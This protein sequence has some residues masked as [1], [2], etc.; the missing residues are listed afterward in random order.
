MNT[1]ALIVKVKI[2]KLG[3]TEKTMSS[4]RKSIAC[5]A[6]ARQS[7]PPANYYDSAIGPTGAVLKSALHG[8]IDGHTVLP[9]TATATDTW[10]A[11]RTQDF[12]SGRKTLESVGEVVMGLHRDAGIVMK[13]GQQIVTDVL[14]G[15]RNHAHDRLNPLRIA[16]VHDRPDE[17]AALRFHR[18]EIAQ[19][20]EHLKA[21]LHRV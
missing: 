14:V 2:S 21:R 17:G 8:I 5:T 7:M 3:Q 4:P 6:R 12:R 18:T 1:K 16:E 19:V 20:S 9:Y 10:D 13:M 15:V 11:R